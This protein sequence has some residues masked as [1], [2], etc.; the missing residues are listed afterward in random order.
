MLTLAQADYLC[1]CECEHY[2]SVQPQLAH[3]HTS[4][5]SHMHIWLLDDQALVLLPTQTKKIGYF[6]V[7]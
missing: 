2:H 7:T 5:H 6:G 1:V 3:T 4:T